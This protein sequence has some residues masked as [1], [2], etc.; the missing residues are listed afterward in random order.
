MALRS[1]EGRHGHEMGNDTPEVAQSAPERRWWRR[2]LTLPA[3]L[4]TTALTGAVS[5]WVTQLL[6]EASAERKAQDPVSVSLETNPS[7]IGGASDQPINAM[8]PGGKMGGDPGPGCDGF[9]PWVVAQ[10]GIDAGSTKVQIIVQGRVP[11]PVQISNFRVHVHRT[12]PPLTGTFVECPPAA[13][14]QFRAIA[15]DLDSTPPRVTYRSPSGNPFGFTLKEGESE[16][17][18]V[19]ATAQR[20]YYEWFVELDLV[21]NGRRQTIRVSDNGKPFQTNPAGS[22]SWSWN[23]SDGWIRDRSDNDRPGETVPAGRPLPQ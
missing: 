4:T 9:R 16:T 22:E 10:G 7:R 23:Y 13:E 2:L 14:A 3:I 12:S 15:V 18:N 6:T 19:I 8:F 11:D 5:W 21:V 17:F 1:T 20:R